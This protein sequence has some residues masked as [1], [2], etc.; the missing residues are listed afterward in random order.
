MAKMAAPREKSS[1]NKGDKMAA[2]TQLRRET[3][4]LS[5]CLKLS[6]PTKIGQ[7]ETY[8]KQRR[9]PL[10]GSL[11]SVEIELKWIRFQLGEEAEARLDSQLQLSKANQDFVSFEKSTSR[12][13]SE[14]DVL[15]IDLE[16]A[17]S[18][19]RE[20]QK[21]SKQLELINIEFKSKLD[22]IELTVLYDASQRDIIR[23]L[24]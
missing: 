12:L 22:K 21:H 3:S 13:Q 17:N 7:V 14:L 16:K 19:A 5:L 24:S 4:Q 11:H 23:L 2:P 9:S 8:T 20:M 18:T 1:Q 10:E 6:Q 15:I